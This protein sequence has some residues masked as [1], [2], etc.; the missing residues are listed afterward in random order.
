MSCPYVVE[1]VYVEVRSF[2]A[3]RKDPANSICFAALQGG[4]PSSMERQQCRDE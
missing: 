1:L 2:L 4:E 3:V